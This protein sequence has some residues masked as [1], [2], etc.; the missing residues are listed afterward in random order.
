MRL[1]VRCGYETIS[2]DIAPAASAGEALHLDVC[3]APDVCRALRGVDAVFHLAGYGQALSNDR[4]L[5][6]CRAHVQGT[7]NLVHGCIE[8]G[9]GWVG[10]ASTFLVYRGAAGGS[11]SEDSVIDPMLLDP[12]AASKLGAELALVHL[13]RRYGMRH[14]ILRYG[15]AYGSSMSSNVVGAFQRCL[16]R[17]EPIEVWGDG[18]RTLQL[19]HVDDLAEGSVRAL[20]A[21]DGT[22]N[23]VSGQVTSIAELAEHF[24]R[25]YGAEVRHDLSRPQL[26]PVPVVSPDKARTVLGWNPMDIL[27]GLRRSLDGASPDD[28][29]AVGTSRRR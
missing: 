17:R 19:T 13:A 29:G 5:D 23:L 16:E 20:D 1:L 10:L 28:N 27:T 14:T 26:P 6:A 22:Y 8:N 18:S 21:P 7:L 15:S 12:F 24:H 11:A 3:S 9:V 4:L 2:A 25:F